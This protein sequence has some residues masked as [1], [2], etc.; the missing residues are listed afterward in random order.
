M[1]RP[2]FRLRTLMVATICIAVTLRWAMLRPYP[3]SSWGSANYM[4]SWSDGTGTTIPGPVW[5]MMEITKYHWF[6]VVT[7]PDGSRGIYLTPRR[8]S[9]GHSR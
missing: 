5:N 3:V 6:I 4:I 8:R 7:W 1:P 2:R 9:A